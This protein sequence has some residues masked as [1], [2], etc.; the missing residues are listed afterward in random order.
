MKGDRRIG[1][2][3]KCQVDNQRF[4]LQCL[5]QGFN[6]K[7]SMM[8]RYKSI[9][10]L[11]LLLLSGTINASDDV[12]TTMKSY[13]ND[14]NKGHSANDLVRNYFNPTAMFVT[15]G[16]ILNFS[17]YQESEKWM[18]AMLTDIGRAGW[19]RSEYG[20]TTVCKLSENVA[21]YGF[22]LRRVF[23]D[24]SETISGG[25]YTLFKSDRWRIAV[26]IFVEPGELVNCEHV[27][28]GLNHTPG[29]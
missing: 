1:D 7:T 14:F 26:A 19:V 2:R 6:I 21:I 18:G 4:P 22:H 11:F 8:R 28:A 24:G 15:P 23:Q 29:T 5:R 27:D 3:T 25:A 9:V 20:E 12:A 13:L 10:F 16:E 17:S